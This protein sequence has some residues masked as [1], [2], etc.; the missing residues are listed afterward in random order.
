MPSGPWPVRKGGGS[1]PWP[2]EQRALDHPIR[3]ADMQRAPKALVIGAAGNIG[4]PLVTHLRSVGY[5]VL[6]VDLRPGWRPDY[7]MADITHSLD[8]LPA[9]DWAPDVVFLLAGGVARHHDQPG[10]HQQRAPAVQAH[11][12]RV[13]VLLDLGSVWTGLRR[14]GRG[15]APST[16][17]PLWVV[18]V[19]GR[20]VGGIRGAD[21]PAPGGDAA[22]LHD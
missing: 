7:L 17:Q 10:R 19:A 15:I 13:R 8:L 11:P 2:P 16:E 14:A 4:S 20:A 6:E 22:A 1:S 12:Q 3:T 5:A 9:F 21:R 18:E